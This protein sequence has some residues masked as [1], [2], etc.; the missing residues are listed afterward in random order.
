MDEN[1]LQ[2]R[3]AF[4]KLRNDLTQLI[5]RLKDYAATRGDD[6]RFLRLSAE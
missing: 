3:P 5:E 2:R 6:L 1:T 4:T